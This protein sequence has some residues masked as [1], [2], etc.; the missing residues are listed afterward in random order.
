MANATDLK[1]LIVDD[2]RTMRHV[3]CMLLK[4]M[5]C[6]HTEEAENG[7]VALQML[8][9]G[10]FDFVI[11]D[12]NM[13]EMNGLDLLVAIKADE[14][15]KRLPVLLVTTEMYPRD[16]DFAMQQGAEDYII[17]PFTRATLEE[18]VQKIL[19]KQTPTV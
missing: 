6:N 9:A 13:P 11:S 2:F 1:F 16:R 14:S 15:L 18:K 3:V 17:K 10:Q 8:R 19:A 4:E 5:G 12:V 7:V